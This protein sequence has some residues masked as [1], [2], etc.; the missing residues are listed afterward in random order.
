MLSYTDV[1]I[2]MIKERGWGWRE[3]VNGHWNFMS[4]DRLTLA[5]IPFIPS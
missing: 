1:L 2:K 4:H 3:V 5:L